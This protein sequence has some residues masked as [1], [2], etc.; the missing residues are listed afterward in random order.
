MSGNAPRKPAVLFGVLAVSSALVVAGSPSIAM[1][2][3]KVKTV[4]AEV[5]ALDKFNPTNEL[6]CGALAFVKWQDPPLTVEAIPVAWK[7]FYTDNATGQERSESV[8]PPFSDSVKHV[9]ADY[10]VGGGAHWWSISWASRGGVGVKDKGCSDLAEA[11]LAR[12][13]GPARV[14]I[15]LDLKE[16]PVNQKKCKA[17]RAE[18]RERNKA[19]GKLLGKLRRATNDDAKDQI[20]EQLANARNKRANAARKMTKACT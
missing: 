17:A 2:E 1:A 19:V 16:P 8:M 10:L 9:G 4:P 3:T 11:M 14:E 18:L 12:Y 5:V 15:T 7:V 13:G 20:R 6:Q